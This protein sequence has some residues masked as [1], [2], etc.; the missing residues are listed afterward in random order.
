MK[1]FSKKAFSLIELIFVIAILSVIAA[2]AVP[3]L[4]NSKSDAIVSTIKKDI[5]TITTSVQS[6]YVVNEGIEKI[7]DAVNINE[8]NWIVNNN[9]LEFKHNNKLCVEININD[10]KLNVIITSN[11]EDNIC[12]KIYESGVRSVS[13]DLL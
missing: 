2:V 8:K 13:Y 1:N 7:T 9:K 3:K 10:D 5:S 4:L 11:S 12:K 6:Y